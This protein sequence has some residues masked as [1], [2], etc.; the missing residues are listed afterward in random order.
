MAAYA[1]TSKPIKTTSTKKC[2]DRRFR[3]SICRYSAISLT[4]PWPLITSL[5]RLRRASV[6]GTRRGAKVAES[7]RLQYQLRGTW[8]GV[9]ATIETYSR[10]GHFQQHGH[11]GHSPPK[12]RTAQGP[13]VTAR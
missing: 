1:K 2:D 5:L 4:G 6:R 11:Y 9:P 3:I 13:G 8:R 7:V 10:S 12:C